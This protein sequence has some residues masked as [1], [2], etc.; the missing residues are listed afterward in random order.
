MIF[1]IKREIEFFEI[2]NMLSNR[3]D[4]QIKIL[5]FQANE[6]TN[7]NHEIDI[8][9]SN[10]KIKSNTYIRTLEKDDLFKSLDRTA[11]A[12]IDRKLAMV[13]ELK[14]NLSENFGNSIV[15]SIYSNNKIFVSS[16]TSIFESLWK[17]ID[18]FEKLE[19]IEKKF[20]IHEN[21][22]EKQIQEKTQNLLRINDEL[23]ELNREFERKEIELKRTNKELIETENKKEEF[24]SMIAHELRS[25][26]VP[27][28]GYTEM[29]LISKKMGQLTDIQ[30]KALS[31]IYRNVKKQESLVE[32][33]LDV[34]K[35]DL[36]KIILSKEEVLISQM[37]TNVLNDLKS[38]LEAKQISVI[39]ELNLNKKSTVYCDQKRIEQVLSNLIKNSIDFVPEKNG[40]ITVIAEGTKELEKETNKVH[41]SSNVMFTIQD[42][43]PGMPQDKIGNLFKK[44]YQMDTSAT[45]KHTGTG[46]GLVICKG[47]IEA[48]NGRIWIDS[49][50]KEGFKIMFS[51][52]KHN[53]NSNSK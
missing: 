25:P 1:A 45:R 5:L 46:L 31:S 35:L 49:N 13:L 50:H 39:T 29:L 44:F 23:K 41:H 16:Y 8:I 40:K 10:E 14:D 53:Y 3:V 2:I 37:F 18:L 24:I 33:I 42:N 51:I 11:I 12:I 47:L 30:K 17:Y 22:L 34:Y 26:L 15:F 21:N 48:H 38:L 27:I 9:V 32:D 4:F 6:T 20:K 7:Y 43:G 52:P 36:G 28:K 19:G